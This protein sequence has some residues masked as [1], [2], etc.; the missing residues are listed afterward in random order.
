MS[1]ENMS[2]EKIVQL[3]LYALPL[4][5]GVAIVVLSLLPTFGAGDPLDGA[6]AFPLLGIGMF[7]LALA[8]LNKVQEK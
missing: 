1:T 5:F 3:I 7:T 6:T 4:A 8:G 2:F